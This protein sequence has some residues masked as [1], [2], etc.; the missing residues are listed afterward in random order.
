[1]NGAVAHRRREMKNDA[2]G[3]KV[4]HDSVGAANKKEQ[5]M[6]T[7]LKQ[8]AVSLLAVA[9]VFGLVPIVA[10]ADQT[11]GYVSRTGGKFIA[12]AYNWRGLVVSGNAATGAQTVIIGYNNSLP[13]GRQFLPFGA[14]GA[15]LSPVT[16]DQG[17]SQETLTPTAVSNIQCPLT[18]Q[19]GPQIFCASFTA[20]FGFTHGLNTVVTSGTYGLQEAITDAWFNGGGPV[21]IDSAFGYK[22]VN[23]LPTGASLTNPT[24]LSNAWVEDYRSGLSFWSPQP[25]LTPITI[26]TILNTGTNLSTAT[27]GGTIATGAAVRVCIQ[28]VD[29]FGGETGCSTD[30]GTAVVTTGA[31][32]TNSITI[33]AGGVPVGTGIVGYRV[34]A[35][36]AAGASLSETQVAV[37]NMTYTVAPQCP[38]VN[39]VLPAAAVI[40]TSLP[41]AT[42]AG[43]I[44]GATGAAVSAAH[45]TIA[46]RQGHVAPLMLPF[47]NA[48]PAGGFAVTATSPASPGYEMGEI[49]YPAGFFNSQSSTYRIC[50]GGVA[51]ATAATVAGQWNIAIGPRVNSLGYAVTT[52]QIAVSYLQIASMN[53]TAGGVQNFAFCTDVTTI[54]PGSSGTLEGHASFFGVQTA[55]SGT[56]VNAFSTDHGVAVSSA[57]DLTQQGVI[58]LMYFES[59]SSWTSPQLRYLS[60][61]PVN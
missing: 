40:I 22:T 9:L 47:Q 29:I 21:V 37:A 2:L 16:F 24:G 17:A 28:A 31:G 58:S 30:T 42:N 41:A 32:A 38:L 44:V 18:G 19:F 26:P 50:G 1:M 12:S 56:T 36:A 34:Y 54:T 45:T 33:A 7:Y 3:K 25:G 4:F 52:Q 35:T 13:D 55:S 43:P 46:I 53:W 48:V 20:T 39:C 60:I 6:K 61:T 15:V 57:I 59:A 14:T 49:A 8:F 5:Q 11:T 23:S 10:Q 51:T 27:T